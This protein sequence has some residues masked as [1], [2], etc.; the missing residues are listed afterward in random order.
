[1]R[2]KTRSGELGFIVQAPLKNSLNH[3][4]PNCCPSQQEPG[5]ERCHHDSE[6][7]ARIKAERCEAEP[8]SYVITFL[9]VFVPES[10]EP[11]PL[12]IEALSFVALHA[13]LS[14]CATYGATYALML[15]IP[16]RH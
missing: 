10:G 15:V 6:S 3:I 4:N 12:T 1:M 9:G 7:D 2:S 16:T 13:S 14:L 5:Q 8:I 11:R